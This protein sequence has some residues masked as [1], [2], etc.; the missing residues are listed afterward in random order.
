[1]LQKYCDNHSKEKFDFETQIE[2]Q[3]IEI[4]KLRKRLLYSLPNSTNS[5]SRDKEHLVEQLKKDLNQADA[6]LKNNQD[7]Y[8]ELQ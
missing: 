8:S 5:L 4:T 6:T 1:M 2:D 3:E 7:D